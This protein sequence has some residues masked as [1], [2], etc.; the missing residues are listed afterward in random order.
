MMQQEAKW[1]YKNILA[2]EKNKK[3][4]MNLGSSTN[5]FRNNIQPHISKELF[6]PLV[7]FGYKVFHVDVKDDKGVDIVGDVTKES[8]LQRLSEINPGAVVCSNLLEHLEDRELFC[9]S[10]EKILSSG[11]YLFVTC[12]NQY[13]YHPDP[14]DTMFRPDITDL[15]AEF[16]NL[17]LIKGE[18]LNCGSYIVQDEY[19][20]KHN[21]KLWFKNRL[22]LYIK[23]L[24]P[25]YKPF[26]WYRLIT[27]RDEIDL[28]QAILVTCLVMR[29][30]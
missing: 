2:H 30:N 11:S 24:L 27:K 1:L 7:N 4:L 23:Y 10:V 3:L 22:K 6:D 21:F 28:N 20:K 9:K 25:F 17:N 13:R 8:F 16:K 26:N 18:I 29:K 15:A 19:N 12:P 14:I 5:N